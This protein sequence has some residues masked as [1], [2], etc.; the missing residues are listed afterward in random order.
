VHLFG[1]YFTPSKANIANV[2][3][4]DEHHARHSGHES[5]SALAVQRQLAVFAWLLRGNITRFTILDAALTGLHANF[6][7]RIPGTIGDNIGRTLKLIS[8]LR[9][10]FCIKATVTAIQ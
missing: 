8:C 6:P 4:R 5:I 3:A 7:A 1:I 2:C 9:P 10:Y